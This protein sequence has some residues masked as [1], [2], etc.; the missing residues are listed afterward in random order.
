MK[1]INFLSYEYNFLLDEV[2]DLV[3]YIIKFIIGGQC[4]VLASYFSQMKNF[5]WAGIITTLPIMTIANMLLQMSV[6]N[7]N[8]FHRTQK[9]GILG[10]FGLGLFVLVCFICTYWFKPITAMS[11]SILFYLIYI[12]IS[13]QFL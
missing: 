6:L 13:R 3:D 12:W 4:L 11:L 2:D 8:E 9:S 7:Q 1:I 5:F 10:G